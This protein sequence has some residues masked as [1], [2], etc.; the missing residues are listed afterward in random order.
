MST[1]QTFRSS[2]SKIAAAITLLAAISVFY[3][4]LGTGLFAIHD[5]EDV[6]EVM[7]VPT[8][9]YKLLAFAL[10]SALAGLVGGIHALFINYVTT[11]DTFTIALPLT[12]ILMCVLGGSRHWAGPAVG[13][14]LITLL[15]YSFTGGDSA[16]IG[17]GITGV[18]LIGVILFMPQGVLGQ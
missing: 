18:V 5:D 2:L 13:A 12:V 4:R 17:K 7:G 8:Y 11:G 9:R 6:A 15:L 14:I 10:S 3:S 1:F 16:I